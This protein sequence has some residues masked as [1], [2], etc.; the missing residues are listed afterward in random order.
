MTGVV[1]FEEVPVSITVKV[2]VP[3]AAI[4]DWPPELWPPQ[5]P[6]PAMR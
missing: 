2:L 6:K 3:G 5:P 1:A 4:P